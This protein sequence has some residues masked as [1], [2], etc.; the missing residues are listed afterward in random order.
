MI[1]DR[2]GDFM[3]YLDM[4]CGLL[5]F[6]GIPVTI[7]VMFIV[8]LVLF[9]KTPREDPK[10]KKR[11]RMFIVFSVLLALLLASVIWLITMLSIGIA[12]M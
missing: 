5:V 4:I 2:K 8:S 10:H 6:I 12:H 7:L 3:E 1:R 9:V 11:L